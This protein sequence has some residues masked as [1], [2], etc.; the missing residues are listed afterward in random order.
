MSLELS[1]RRYVSYLLIPSKLYIYIYIYYTLKNL[2]VPYTYA[3]NGIVK[4]NIMLSE[5]NKNITEFYGMPLANA[6]AWVQCYFLLNCN[7]S[8]DKYNC[9]IN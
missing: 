3:N 9:R 6:E 4:T 1:R 2:W 5:C 8:K 7:F